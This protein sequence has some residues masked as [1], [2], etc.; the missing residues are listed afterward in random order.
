MYNLHSFSVELESI[1]K[2]RHHHDTLFYLPSVIRGCCQ[3]L[4]HFQSW[5]EVVMSNLQLL[6]LFNCLP[7]PFLSPLITTHPFHWFSPPIVGGWGYTMEGITHNLYRHTTLSQDWRTDQ[8]HHHPKRWNY[9]SFKLYIHSCHGPK[10][11][12]FY[13]LTVYVQT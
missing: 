8:R 12:W 1:Q 6:G 5:G 10:H 7:A 4:S 3:S 13:L 11:H 2:Y 9:A